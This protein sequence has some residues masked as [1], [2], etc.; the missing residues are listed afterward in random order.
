MERK[1]SNERM[2]VIDSKD[3]RIIELQLLKDFIDDCFDN[4]IRYYICSGT[5]L[6][7][8]RHKGFIPWDDDIDVLMPRPDYEIFMRAKKR[9]AFIC[10]ENS[11]SYL[12][13]FGKYY[14][15]STVLIEDEHPD[16]SL[17]G[18]YIDVFPIDGVGNDKKTAIKTARKVI[19]LRRMYYYS[20]HKRITTNCS[21][22]KLPFKAPFYLL[23]KML[24]RDYWEKKIM[25]ILR[26]KYDETKYVGSIVS[27]YNEREIFERKLFDDVD[28][29]DFEGIKVISVKDYNKYLGSLYGDYM[30]LPEESKRISNHSFVA[31]YKENANE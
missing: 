23:A 12:Y 7:A 29:Y 20:I 13:M 2:K 15:E 27:G 6:G 10:S 9:N 16:L 28:E 30:K 25:N 8:I 18:V 31:Y 11:N 19:S 1:E 5:L 4:H 21:I 22:F 24:G 26:Y 3:L 14:F 17:F